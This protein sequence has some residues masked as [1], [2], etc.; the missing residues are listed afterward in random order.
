[1]SN[2]TSFSLKGNLQQNSVE[3]GSNFIL[4]VNI[5]NLGQEAAKELD[6]QVVSSGPRVTVQNPFVARESKEICSLYPLSQ[7]SF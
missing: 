2:P 7:L 4:N 6:I 1:M 5:K 3:E